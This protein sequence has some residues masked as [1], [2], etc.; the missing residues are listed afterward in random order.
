MWILP[1][2][3]S[4]TCPLARSLSCY[5]IS[6]S[7]LLLSCTYSSL[8]FTHSSLL[9]HLTWGW[10]KCCGLIPIHSLPLSPTQ[11][12][13]P[14]QWAGLPP[15]C[16]TLSETQL[17]SIHQGSLEF[18]CIIERIISLRWHLSIINTVENLYWSLEDIL[19][20]NA[21]QRCQR[22]DSATQQLPSRWWGFGSLL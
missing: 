3:D 17:C 19:H 11:W 9:F 12:P 16:L 4:L 21:P 1:A 15:Q 8:S 7:S 10:H 2:C 20:T 22:E 13:P 5:S 14:P 18:G 6:P